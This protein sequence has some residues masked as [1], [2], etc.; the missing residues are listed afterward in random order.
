MKTAGE[1]YNSDPEN[2]RLLSDDLFRVCLHCLLDFG[3]TG[4]LALMD[5]CGSTDLAVATTATCAAVIGISEHDS[6]LEQTIFSSLARLGLRALDEVM[7][8]VDGAVVSD[9]LQEGEV[10]PHRDRL[11]AAEL[12]NPIYLRTASHG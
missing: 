3:T 7:D 5:L 10:A 1:G 11:L 8:F 9:L 6:Q 12:A 2:G 4:R